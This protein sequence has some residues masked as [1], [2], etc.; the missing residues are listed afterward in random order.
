M[1][2]VS[3]NPLIDPNIG[4]DMILSNL[5]EELNRIHNRRSHKSIMMDL[6]VNAKKQISPHDKKGVKYWKKN[7]N[8][9]DIIGIDDMVSNEPI[10][11]PKRKSKRMGGF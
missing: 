10:T 2:G 5:M 1:Y 4:E 8:L 3:L 7:P 9:C 6:S 11:K